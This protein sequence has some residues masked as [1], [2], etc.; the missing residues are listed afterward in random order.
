[1]LGILGCQSWGIPRPF[2]SGHAP[3][4]II[5]NPTFIPVSD[6]NLL[7]DQTVIAVDDHFKIRREQRVRVVADQLTEGRLETF[8]RIGSTLLEPWHTDSTKGYEKLESTLQTIRR[9]AIVRVS[10]QDGGFMVEVEVH[11]QMEDLPKSSS[12]GRALDR[13]R[14][15]GTLTRVDGPD[16][17]D[18]L[19]E[20]W[21]PLCRDVQLEQRILQDIR[22]RMNQIEPVPH[23]PAGYP[24]PENYPL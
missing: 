4:R 19:T 16:D 14:S 23:I 18:P 2:S 6:Y 9:Y 15:D 21:I 5:D 1:M 8:P 12:S 22:A 24:L 10:P 7:W 11:K 3:A 20:G 13:L 17:L